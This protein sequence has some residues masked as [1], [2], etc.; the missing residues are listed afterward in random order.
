MRLR[1]AFVGATC[2]A[3][4]NRANERVAAP[5]SNSSP[6]FARCPDHRGG[7]VMTVRRDY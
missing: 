2:D 1:S 3:L 5:L 4:A 7:Q 6:P